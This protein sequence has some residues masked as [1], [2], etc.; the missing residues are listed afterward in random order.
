M[1]RDSTPAFILLTFFAVLFVVSAWIA[2]PP[3]KVAAADRSLANYQLTDELTPTGIV[4]GMPR[5]PRATSP[6]V[7]TVKTARQPLDLALAPASFVT[8]VELTFH[9]GDAE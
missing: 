2:P 5:V 1:T 6:V 9:K 7:V 4:M 3:T 8:D